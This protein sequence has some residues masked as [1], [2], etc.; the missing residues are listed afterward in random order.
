[1][2][3]ELTP[4]LGPITDAVLVGIV[5]FL[6]IGAALA[7]LPA[8]GERGVPMRVR[9]A[10]AIAFT[11]VVAPAMAPSILPQIS[12]GALLLQFFFTETA[13]GLVLGLGIRMFI[14]VLQTAGEMAAQS[15]SLAQIFAGSNTAEALPAFGNLF[16]F[17]GLA[18][19]TL[20]GLHIKV[21]AAFI[22]SYQIFPLGELVSAATL[23]EWGIH[24]VSRVFSFAFSLA[25]PFIIVSLVYNLALGVINRAMPQL[26]VAFVGAP[27]ISGGGIIVLFLTLPTILAVWLASFDAFL[28]DPT[29]LR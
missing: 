29:I 9:I 22:L 12:D 21:A 14:F 17:S 3:P 7:V 5:V 26:M 19:A 16:L 10:I 27:A 8:F 28:A 11:L 13:A 23:S 25:A 6:R 2:S 4:Y 24:R 20:A 15:A 1:M 18:L